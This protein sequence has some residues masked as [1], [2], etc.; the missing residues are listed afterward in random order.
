MA[1]GF[2]LFAGSTPEIIR[3]SAKEAEAVGFTEK[4]GTLGEMFQV[5]GESDL[6]L[7][8]IS[9]AAQAELFGR[10]FEHLKPG[11]TLV[12]GENVNQTA[13]FAL[14]GGV[15]AAFI[16]YSIVVAPGF[17]DKGR[18]VLL[19]ESLHDPIVQRMVLVKGAG[20]TARQLYEFVLGPEARAILERYGFGIPGS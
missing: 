18:A 4:N 11:A 14:S 20:V 19:P 6:V 9:D 10:V 7:L 1:R 13:Q 5:I 3:A 2:A 17:S 16:P 8:L 15:E 12:L